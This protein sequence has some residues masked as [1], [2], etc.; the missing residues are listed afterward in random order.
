MTEKIKMLSMPLQKVARL[1]YGTIWFGCLVGFVVGIT[2]FVG[3]AA[4]IGVWERANVVL[5]GELAILLGFV[6]T[7]IT[8]WNQM[9]MGEQWSNQLWF[10]KLTSM[11]SFST[12]GLTISAV[13]F[14]VVVYIVHSNGR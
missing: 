9:R 6:V 5:I 1:P 12:F 2:Y 10:E 3:D 11:L 7:G 13:V 4:L 14:N 8:K